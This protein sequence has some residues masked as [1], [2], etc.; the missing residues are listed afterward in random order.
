MRNTV[1]VTCDCC[2]KEFQTEYNS[3]NFQCELCSDC[4]AEYPMY[5]D[6]DLENKI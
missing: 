3:T 6:S 5:I 2:E 4:H 1:V